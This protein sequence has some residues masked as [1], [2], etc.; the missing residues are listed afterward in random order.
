VCK[1]EHHREFPEPAR[2]LDPL[3]PTTARHLPQCE[4][5]GEEDRAVIKMALRIKPGMGEGYDWVECNG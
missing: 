2:R 1:T 5:V 4:L 3:D